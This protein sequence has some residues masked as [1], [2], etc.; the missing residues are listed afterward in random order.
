MMMLQNASQG[1][2]VLLV[3][4]IL[5][6]CSFWAWFFWQ[7]SATFGL[8]WLFFCLLVLSIARFHYEEDDFGAYLPRSS[9]THFH[10]QQNINV[11]MHVNN[12]HTGQEKVAASALSGKIIDI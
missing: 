8:L 2:R 7:M 5:I 6:A 3:L 11:Y 1:A 12:L 4:T 9:Q 10:I